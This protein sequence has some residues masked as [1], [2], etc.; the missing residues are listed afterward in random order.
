MKHNFPVIRFVKSLKQLLKL[1]FERNVQLKE[2]DIYLI[3]TFVE[4]T[5]VFFT[6]KLEFEYKI[7]IMFDA[8]GK[9]QSNAPLQLGGFWL[10]I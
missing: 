4:K 7:D 10:K 2:W 9:M 5:K 8:K 6:Q 3:Q 1:F